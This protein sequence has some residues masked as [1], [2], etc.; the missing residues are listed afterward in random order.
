MPREKHEIKLFIARDE[1]SAALVKLLHMIL[2]TLPPKERPRVKLHV[3]KIDDVKKFP[4][5]L[6]YLEEI[7]GGIHTFE[8][9]RYN[10]MQLPAI[11]IDDQKVLEGEF[12][13][14]EQLRELLISAGIL[15]P[16]KIAAM[17]A[18]QPIQYPVTGES[19][20]QEIP[21]F[22]PTPNV[23]TPS[24]KKEIE[25]QEMRPKP[26]QLKPTTIPSAVSTRLEKPAYTRREIEETPPKKSE[27]LES[28]QIKLEKQ[29]PPHETRKVEHVKEASRPVIKQS[30]RPEDLRGTCFDCIFYDEKRGRCLR[31]SMQVPDPYNPPCGRRRK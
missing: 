2:E 28:I 29:A 22:Q 17:P 31:M 13:N 12:P 24:I 11:V 27:M 30:K 25:T 1:R 18:Q 19:Q 14:E 8:F 26:E 16:P 9:R 21:Q 23:K 5:F 15:L 7:Y 6:A 20:I 10:I 3:V 4:E